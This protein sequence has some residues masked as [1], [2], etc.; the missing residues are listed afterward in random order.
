MCSMNDTVDR[1][2]LF[3]M[4]LYMDMICDFCTANISL[5]V[6]EIVENHLSDLQRNIRLR[7]DIRAD[8]G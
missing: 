6:I 3:L 5:Q 7:E 1:D 4:T 2:S 8:K